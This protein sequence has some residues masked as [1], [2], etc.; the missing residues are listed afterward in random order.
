M[1][2]FASVQR[3]G[4]ARSARG[5]DEINVIVA[6]GSYGLLTSRETPRSVVQIHPA[7]FHKQLYFRRMFFIRKTDC[8]VPS[9]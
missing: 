1:Y 6:E 3:G 8:V 2:R 7:L 9:Q 4:A 5:N